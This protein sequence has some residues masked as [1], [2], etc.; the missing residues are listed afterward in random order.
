M[1]L[2]DGSSSCLEKSFPNIYGM[3]LFDTNNN[4]ACTENNIPMSREMVSLSCGKINYKHDKLQWRAP[5]WHPHA[6]PA[7][8]NTAVAACTPNHNRITCDPS[9]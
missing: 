5:N 4:V 9:F 3:L 7:L 1:G 6:R 8:L 2:S